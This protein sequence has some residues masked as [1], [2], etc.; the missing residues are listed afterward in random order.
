MRERR[1]V[2][3]VGQ[4]RAPLRQRPI[5]ARPPRRFEASGDESLAL[6]VG[7]RADQQAQGDVRARREAPLGRLEVA[8]QLLLD[9]RVADHGQRVAQRLHAFGGRIGLHRVAEGDRHRLRRQRPGGGRRNGH[10]RQHAADQRAKPGRVVPGGH[11]RG[12]R[13][14]LPFVDIEHLVGFVG[15]AAVVQRVE[16]RVGEFESLAREFEIGR[17]A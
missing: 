6:L 12:T 7:L 10:P 15:Q 14:R 5:A 4:L 3:R 11:A 8:R 13:E 17:L 9:A 1:A 2:G 16:P